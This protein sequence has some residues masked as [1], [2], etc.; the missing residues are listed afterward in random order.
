MPQS[1][2]GIPIHRRPTALFLSGSIGW[3]SVAG[4]MAANGS[5][6]QTGTIRAIVLAWVLTLPA[7]MLIA[8][9][10]YFILRNIL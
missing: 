6:L 4:T 5:G 2:R 9:C 10:L 3:S 7:A 1:R 8:G